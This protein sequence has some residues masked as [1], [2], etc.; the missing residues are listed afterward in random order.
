[1]E[2]QK[3]PF[4]MWYKEAELIAACLRDFKIYLTSALKHPSSYFYLVG[5][6][7]ILWFILRKRVKSKKTIVKIDERLKELL[8]TCY[9]YKK[10]DTQKNIKEVIKLQSK[11]LSYMEGIGF[12]AKVKLEG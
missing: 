2:Y 12:K 9:E 1:M 8:K 5:T 11:F 4:C 6:T 7:Q 3:S 10:E